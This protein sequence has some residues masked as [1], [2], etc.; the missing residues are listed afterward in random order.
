MV[1]ATGLAAAAAAAFASVA[2]A[3]MQS[4]A[5]PTASMFQAPLG[6]PPVKTPRFTFTSPETGAPIDFFQMDMKPLSRKQ[7]PNLGPARMLG[8]DGQMPGMF[9]AVIQPY[10][11]RPILILSRSHLPHDPGS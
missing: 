2:S 10:H 11:R 3:G 4:P 7:Y 6:Q 1:K 8:Y 5:F 9:R